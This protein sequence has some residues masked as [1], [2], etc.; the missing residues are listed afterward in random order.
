[1]KIDFTRHPYLPVED[2][3]DK[4]DNCTLKRKRKD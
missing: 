1:M 3:K 2:T 4:G